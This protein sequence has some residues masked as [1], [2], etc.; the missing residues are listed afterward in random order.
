MTTHSHSTPAQQVASDVMNRLVVGG[1]F[2]TPSNRAQF[3]V[4][5]IGAD[6]YEITTGANDSTLRITRR[7]I[8]DT[9]LF[10]QAHSATANAPIE[11][12][13]DNP[14][15]T[16]SPLC[17]VARGGPNRPRIVTYILPILAAFG[18][19]AISAESPNTVWIVDR[20][21]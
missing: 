15:A 2:S 14:W 16:A 21:V 8:E 11:I 6:G 4:S 18:H 17:R 9:Y 19:V 1:E 7:N 13:S 20:Q 10:L 3:R 5:Q 12:G